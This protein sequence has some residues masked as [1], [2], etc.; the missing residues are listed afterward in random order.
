ME[1]PLEMGEMPLSEY[2]S[3]LLKVVKQAGG[4]ENA[5]THFDRASTL[6]PK[7]L[8][9]S[10]INPIEGAVLPLRVKQNLTGD[11]HKGL[12][13][14][15]ADL[16]LRMEREIERQIRMMTRKVISF[17]DATPN[18]AEDGLVAINV[19]RKLK[20]KYEG[21]IDFQIAVSPI[22]GFK[23]DKSNRWLVYQ[24]AA[25]Q[26][27]I[28]GGLPEK[29]D[30]PERIG[31]KQHVKKILALGIEMGKEVHFQVDQANDP[32]ESGTETLIEAAEWFGTP[33]VAAA[34][35][36]DPTLWAIH[37][38]SPSGYDDARFH[39]MIDG[40]LENNIGVIC[41]P[42][43]AL[44]MRQLRPIKTHT[45]NSI[46][47]VLDLLEAGVRVKIGTDNIA[48]IYVPNGD[49]NVL[50]EIKALGNAV[51]F[52]ITNVMAKVGA[53]QVLNNMDREMVKKALDA[54]RDVFANTPSTT[55]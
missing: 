43:A 41:C 29:D 13:Y 4:F 39:K 6:D 23:N 2:D 52:Y 24:E 5:H 55:I 49:G 17:I 35:E 1:D 15:P 25:K 38:I 20:E 54:D 27:D 51:R 53:G 3:E 26:S 48:D 21:K 34:P 46:A 18:L 10:G 19:A 14:T 40:L 42:S 33:K 9:H 50:T 28:L 44:S 8:Q 47:R 31:Y 7:Y 30:A 37:S 12:A 11:L 36:G 32:R 45:H 16:E 22:F